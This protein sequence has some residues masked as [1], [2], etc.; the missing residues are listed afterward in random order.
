MPIPRNKPPLAY[1]IFF[2]VIIIYFYLFYFLLGG[3]GGGCGGSL[4]HLISSSFKNHLIYPNGKK[5]S[6]RIR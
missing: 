6:R 5:G 1:N 3:G 2:I 4:F